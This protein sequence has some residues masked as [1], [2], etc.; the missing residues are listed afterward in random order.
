MVDRTKTINQVVGD[1]SRFWRVEGPKNPLRLA[2]E[3]REAEQVNTG[4]A[5]RSRSQQKAGKGA[6][7][8]DRLPI[9]SLDMS[10][11][12]NRNLRENPLTPE[13]GQKIIAYFHHSGHYGNTY[14]RTSAM[15]QPRFGDEYLI[16]SSSDE[17]PTLEQLDLINELRNNG[18]NVNIVTG[19]VRNEQNF[20]FHNNSHHAEQKLL[21]QGSLNIKSIY[22]TNAVCEECAADLYLLNGF[23]SRDLAKNPPRIETEAQT[24]I[25]R[26]GVEV[27]K[28]DSHLVV[29]GMRVERVPNSEGTGVDLVVQV[30]KKFIR[31]T[32]HQ[33]IPPSREFFD[34]LRDKKMSIQQQDLLGSDGRWMSETQ[35]LE[36]RGLGDEYRKFVEQRRYVPPGAEDMTRDPVAPE[37]RPKTMSAAEL[38]KDM[39]EQSIERSGAN[40]DV[41][42]VT[43]DPNNPA[44]IEVRVQKEKKDGLEN[45]WGVP[46]KFTPTDVDTLQSAVEELK[47]GNVNVRV[48][49]EDGN[50]FPIPS[51]PPKPQTPP[52]PESNNE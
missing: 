32:K 12:H 13:E 39:A 6:P 16:A 46:K 29:G 36:Q 19:K 37:S 14:R 3:A 41:T 31:Q 23:G 15:S 52:P 44:T 24:Q 30:P 47:K 5:A 10:F 27:H 40:V 4:N 43:T 45:L 11:L 51:R 34:F 7:V 50:S 28:V 17:P 8:G 1:D 2:R 25:L 38:K 33:H 48:V 42:S 20:P 9:A 49:A 18:L 35:F 21:T 26:G 22:V